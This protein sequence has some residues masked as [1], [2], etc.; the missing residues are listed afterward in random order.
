MIEESWYVG[1]TCRVFLSATL[2][3]FDKSIHISGPVDQKQLLVQLIYSAKTVPLSWL[4]IWTLPQVPI[5]NHI[6]EPMRNGTWQFY[7]WRMHSDSLLNLHWSAA[8]IL[9]HNQSL[10]PSLL[11]EYDKHISEFWA[12]CVSV[13]STFVR[14]NVQ[15]FVSDFLVLKTQS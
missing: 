2:V 8:A 9:C 15:P 12:F 13:W 5:G 3:K 14:E 6:L 11:K 4:S 10:A 1:S 7:A